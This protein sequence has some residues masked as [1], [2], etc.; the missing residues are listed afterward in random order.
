MHACIVYEMAEFL[1]VAHAHNIVRCYILTS[2]L[3][4]SNVPPEA[5]HVPNGWQHGV[6]L[7]THTQV[8]C[9]AQRS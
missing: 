3:S 8:D 7:E 1:V 9:D 6:L 4:N 5:K 2:S